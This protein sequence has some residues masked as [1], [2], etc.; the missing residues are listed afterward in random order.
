VIG[1]RV[2]AAGATS[3][4]AGPIAK[5]GADT[6]RL[7]KPEFRVLMTIDAVGGVW[8]Y[9]MDLALAMQANGIATVFAGLGSRPSK[10]QAAEAQRLGEL[11]WLD[12]PLEWMCSSPAPLDVLPEQLAALATRYEI[13]L[14]HLNAPSQAYRL[15]LGLPVV[16][17]SH[18][19]VVTWWQTM[20]SS[21]LPAEWHWLKARTH[22]GLINAH[23]VVAPSR[24]HAD[25]LGLCYGPLDH[26]SVVHNAV[27]PTTPAQTKDDF[28]FAA[29]R[30]WDEGKNGAVL[31]AAA[32]GICWPVRM[33]GAVDGPERQRFS[34]KH[35]SHCGHL[36]SVEMRSYLRR[37]GVVVSPSLYEP[38][39]LVALEAA[40]V[41]SAL[42]LSD[43]PTY[44]E[45]WADAAEY[46]DPRSQWD[47]TEKLNR[48]AA[49]PNLRAEMGKRAAKR[50]DEYRPRKQAHTMAQLYRSLA[51]RSSGG[52][53]PVH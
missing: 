18:S 39:G 8:R 15:S 13:D 33:A 12:T 40:H 14:L 1:A 29:A 25:V 11:V 32:K 43:I 34:F 30:W 35:A 10:A 47:L 17:V 50:A 5:P 4:S 36:S 45:I 48:L 7:K 6:R 38:F 49:R 19:C 51:I 26:L 20:R 46:F 23:A 22:E 2:N 41:G 44:R 27:Y 37:A 31:D 9:A 42:L 53:V 52:R 28:V 21:P 24:S 16:V 3:L